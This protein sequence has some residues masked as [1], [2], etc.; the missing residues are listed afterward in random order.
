V[1]V[2]AK[3]VP[4]RGW[5]SVGRHGLMAGKCVGWSRLAWLV[6]FV[7]GLGKVAATSQAARGTQTKV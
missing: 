1:S 4:T 2:G 3:L 7:C 6:T 5:L